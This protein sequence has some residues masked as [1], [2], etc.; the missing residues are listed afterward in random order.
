MQSF[1]YQLT[2]M[3]SLILFYEVF[4]SISFIRPSASTASAD[5]EWVRG[6]MH[7]FRFQ[8]AGH[9][10]PHVQQV[11]SS[12]LAFL[13]P[14]CKVHHPRAYNSIVL[15]NKFRENYTISVVY[16]YH[17]YCHTPNFH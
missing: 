17:W 11:L 1:D 13:V 7:W 3:A 5:N 14:A 9:T 12:L 8:T 10:R 16:A 2:V 15:G 6:G 4:S